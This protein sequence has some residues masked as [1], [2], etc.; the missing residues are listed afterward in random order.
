MA[1]ILIPLSGDNTQESTTCSIDDCKHFAQV[2]ID[3]S[4]T[5]V[6]IV[7]NSTYEPYLGMCEYL[8][9]DNPEQDFEDFEDYEMGIL[10]CEPKS[11]IDDIVEGYIFRSLH[12]I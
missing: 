6:E 7:F 8:V 1:K 3:E 12:E 5:I 4:N 11:N 9:V 2:E 10:L